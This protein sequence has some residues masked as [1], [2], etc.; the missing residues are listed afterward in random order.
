MDALIHFVTQH[1]LYGL[2]IIAGALFLIMALVKKMV[3]IAIIVV[4]L[5]AAYGYYLQDIAKH[6]YSRAGAK[7]DMAKDKVDNLMDEAG[8]IIDKT[9]K[10]G[11]LIEDARSLT[12]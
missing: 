1:P 4:I 2:G 10:A 12:E 3:K 9:E 8:V 6:A 7:Y 5:N 11:Q